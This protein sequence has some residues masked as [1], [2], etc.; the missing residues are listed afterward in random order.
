MR[1]KRRTVQ[2]S[3]A[4]FVF[5]AALPAWAS[6]QGGGD[7]KKR[8][9]LPAAVAQA[10]EANRPGVEI[11][12]LEIEKQDGYT[13]YD[14]EFKGDGGEI[15]I[16]Q[17]GTVMDVVDI[18]QMTDVP[19]AAAAAIQRAARGRTIKRIE[20]SE[21]RAKIEKEGGKGRL[22]RL[23]TPEYVYE[24]ELSKGEVEVAADGRIIKGPKEAA[25]P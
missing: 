4:A 8:F 14:I 15:E 1:S 16:A 21:V 10:V 13:L 22:S 18:I 5:G 17:D 12:K 6:A 20:K 23:S 2:V 19:E 11:E 7:A 25:R 24:A 9:N 3:V